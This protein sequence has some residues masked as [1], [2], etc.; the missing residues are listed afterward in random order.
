MVIMTHIHT[1]W[2]WSGLVSSLRMP[3][4]K[5]DGDYRNRTHKHKPGIDAKAQFKLPRKS[6]KGGR[7]PTSGLILIV[8][9]REGSRPDRSVRNRTSPGAP[10][11]T[12]CH[13]SP[14]S[15]LPAHADGGSSLIIANTSP[16]IDQSSVI[17]SSVEPPASAIIIMTSASGFAS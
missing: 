14:T 11:G 7:G 12:S 1:I 3:G 15:L 2:S 10:E 6:T 13:L 17:G 4:G 8:I 5:A 16:G 9:D